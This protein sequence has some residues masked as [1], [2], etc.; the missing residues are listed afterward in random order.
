MFN[1]LINV[2]KG[3]EGQVILFP[4]WVN[5]VVYP[6]KGFSGIPRVSISGNIVLDYGIVDG[7]EHF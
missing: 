3:I 2:E 7:A 6:F 5:H 4:A 1:K